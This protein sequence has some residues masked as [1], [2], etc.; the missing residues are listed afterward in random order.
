M[1]PYYWTKF[2]EV[3]LEG[4]GRFRRIRSTRDGAECL[5]SW[6]G[7][8]GDEYAEAR[9]VCHSVLALGAPRIEARQ[10]SIRAAEA[11]QLHILHILA[12]A[13]LLAL[14]GCATTPATPMEAH[15]NRYA[16]AEACCRHAH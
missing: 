16:G 9:R 10:A 8:R 7:L 6:L 3:E 14:G 12:I 13:S 4:P 15:L 1:E 5:E 11:S 2:V